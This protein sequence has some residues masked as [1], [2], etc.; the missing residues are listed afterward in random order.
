[1]PT[2]VTPTATPMTG[3]LAAV[4]VRNR[5]AQ[6]VVVV[7]GSSSAL[8][9]AGP[10]VSSESDGAIPVWRRL[11]I[12]T[13]ATTMASAPSATPTRRPVL[14][15]YFTTLVAISSETR[16]MTLISGLIAGPAVSLNGSPTVSPITVAACASDPLPPS[17]PSSTSFLALSQAPPELAR[18]TAISTPAAIAPAR[19]EPSGTYPKPNPITMGVSTA[20]RPGVASSRSE[21]FVQMSTTRPYAGFSVKSMI[22][23]CVLN[24]SRTSNTTRPAARP[25]AMISR[26]EKKNTTDA[27]TMRPTSAFGRSIERLNVP[28][29]FPRAASTVVRN[30]PNSAVAAST[31]VAIA[32]P[33]VIAFVVLPTASSRVRTWAAG[34]STSPL[35]SAMPCALSDTG[36]NVSMD[37]ITP[38][39]VSRPVP[40]S[41]TANSAIVGLPVPS[42]NAPYTAAP[43]SS[44]EYTADS[45]PTA[46]PD[47]ITVAGPVRADSVISL[48]GRRLVSVK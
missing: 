26:P 17:T 27:P 12:T 34:P 13:D 32:M 4:I 46:M 15:A 37:T 43:I 25:T 23:G 39:V 40:A 8:G 31:A 21:S 10:P 45:S 33:L 5:C 7:A 35:I 19:N 14:L 18:N 20:S 11:A 6:A 30:A 24:C 29:A 47:R 22:P 28:A 9:A 16:F 2:Q 41:A 38:T 1:M 42:R 48:T 36:P 44:A 3:I